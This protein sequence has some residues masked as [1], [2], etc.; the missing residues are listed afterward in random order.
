[1][2]EAR[3]ALVSLPSRPSGLINRYASWYSRR[4]FGGTV[5]DPVR[6]AS[7]H[8]GV[9]LAQ[10]AEEMLVAKRW[11]RLDET[12]RWLAVMAVSQRIGCSWCMDY[13]WYEGVAIGVNPAKIRAVGNWRAS[14][15]FDERERLA[16]AYAE[17][18]T[19]T[20]ASVDDDLSERLRATFSEDELVELAGYIA[21]ENQRSR[22]NAALGLTS[23]GFKSRCEVP[24]GA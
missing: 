6:A 9:L 14:A 13:G 8:P 18:A 3:M 5:V 15:E 7:H 12:I 10:G 4:R 11:R 1:M 17:A 24:A 20:P 19:D 22:F 16:L 23:Q 21:L 2:K